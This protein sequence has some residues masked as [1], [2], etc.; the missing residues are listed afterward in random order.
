MRAWLVRGGFAPTEDGLERARDAGYARAWA[1]GPGGLVELAAGAAGVAAWREAGTRLGISLPVNPF[2]SRALLA[3]SRRADGGFDVPAL[4]TDGGE[5]PRNVTLRAGAALV[6]LDALT[7]AELVLK[8]CTTPARVLGLADRGHLGVGARADPAVVDPVTGDV[9]ATLGAGRRLWP[10]AGPPP[11]T[12]VLTTA[13]G[14]DAVRAAGLEAEL[15]ASG[16]LERWVRTP[17]A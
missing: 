3:T 16:A 4:A 5:I 11:P 15:V 6:G 2:A 10:P 13:A 8:A 12:R 1:A 7:W 17:A 14:R 9:E